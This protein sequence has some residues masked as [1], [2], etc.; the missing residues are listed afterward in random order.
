MNNVVGVLTC[1]NKFKGSNKP[2]GKIK[3]TGEH[4]VNGVQAISQDKHNTNVKRTFHQE[5]NA[6][7]ATA[8]TQE[9]VQ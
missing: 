8:A 6:A 4:E 7:I 9:E 5:V 2:R 3:D 1:E